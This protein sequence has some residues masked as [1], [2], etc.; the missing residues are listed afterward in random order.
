MRHNLHQTVN[1]FK[2]LKIAMIQL[3][4]LITAIGA[5]YAGVTTTKVH[6]NNEPVAKRFTVIKK[7]NQPRKDPITV[8]GRI[9]DESTGEALIGVS[10]KVK[11][12]ADGTV[13]DLHGN[14]ILNTTSDAVLVVSYIGIHL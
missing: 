12:S 3:L 5:S 7:V 13:S 2:I 8:K 10:I 4:L 14:F 11:N 1:L 6:D 9:K